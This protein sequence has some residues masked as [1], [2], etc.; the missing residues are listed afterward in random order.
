M[1]RTSWWVLSA[2]LLGAILSAGAQPPPLRESISTDPGGIIPYWLILGPVPIGTLSQAAALDY[3]FLHTGSVIRPMPGDKVTVAG[4]ELTWGGVS[5]F[6]GTGSVDAVATLGAQSN[7]LCYLVSYLNLDHDVPAATLSWSSDDSG[8]A[9]VNG[10]EVGRYLGTGNAVLDT[11]LSADFPL[12][13]GVN[14]IMIKA[15]NGDGPWGA[16]ARLIDGKNVPLDDVSIVA[17]PEGKEPPHD[18]YWYLTADAPPGGPPVRT[19]TQPELA[20]LQ[21]Y[22]KAGPVKTGF[23]YSEVPC[24]LHSIEIRDTKTHTV[25][26]RIPADGGTIGTPVRNGYSVSCIISFADFNKPGMYELYTPE[27]AVA[28]SPF[29][30]K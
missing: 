26:Y 9:Y 25:V 27:Y 23:F 29:V 16:S 21:P 8:A 22:A 12:H 1:Y 19:V 20:L 10:V 14:V 6:G 11:D 30:I 7:A 24:R 13:K 15:V 18:F 2:L 17:A 4:K 28:S 5:A 3:D